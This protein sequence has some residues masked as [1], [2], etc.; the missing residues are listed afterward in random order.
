MCQHQHHSHAQTRLTSLS[1]C[2]VTETVRAHVS[3]GAT[4]YS[5][6]FRVPANQKA[7][8]TVTFDSSLVY[9]KAYYIGVPG[10]CE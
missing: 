3:F 8:L 6:K 1:C 4:R 7:T 5:K 9:E 10:P 2:A